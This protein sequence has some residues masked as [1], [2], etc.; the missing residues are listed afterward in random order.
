MQVMEQGRICD[1]RHERRVALLTALRRWV[2]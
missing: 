1:P 2:A